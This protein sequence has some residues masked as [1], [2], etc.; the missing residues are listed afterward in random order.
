[1][2]KEDK[3][4]S[5]LKPFDQHPDIWLA[6]QYISKS[7]LKTAKDR[8]MLLEKAK[9]MILP[10]SGDSTILHAVNELT[11]LLSLPDQNKA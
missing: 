2:Q 3:I 7:K 10:F 11:S 9:N 4:V 5:S 6:T 8:Y 1:M